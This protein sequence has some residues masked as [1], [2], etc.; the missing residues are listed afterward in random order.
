MP[1]CCR[2]SC[3]NAQQCRACMTA[4]HSL[5]AATGQDTGHLTQGNHK[6]PPSQQLLAAVEA[7]RR[8]C[9]TWWAFVGRGERPARQHCCGGVAEAAL[10]ERLHRTLTRFWARRSCPAAGAAAPRSGRSPWDAASGHPARRRPASAHCN[11]LGTLMTRIVIS[12]GSHMLASLMAQVAVARWPL[13][14][15]CSTAGSNACRGSQWAHR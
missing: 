2:L 4:S 7:V 3:S 14:A 11:S 13:L 12:C 15:P 1:A 9:G 10:R 8:K 5:H 6:A